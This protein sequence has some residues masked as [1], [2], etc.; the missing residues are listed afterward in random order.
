M[1]GRTKLRCEKA[2]ESKQFCAKCLGVRM[3]N[4]CTQISHAELWQH[5]AGLGENPQMQLQKMFV[6][7]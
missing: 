5:V 4:L 1:F 6:H 7:R 3:T 2:T